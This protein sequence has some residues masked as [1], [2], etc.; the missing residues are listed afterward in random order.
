MKIWIS[1]GGTGG[2]LFPAIALAEELRARAPQCELLFLGGG[3]TTNR[4]FD[5]ELYPYAEIAC[6]GLGGKN[7]LALVRSSYRIWSGIR[8]SRQLLSAQTPDLVVGFGSFY[9]FPPLVAAAWGRIPLVLFAADR[10]PGRVIRLMARWAQVTA[11][12]FPET[13]S[14]LASPSVVVE[15]PLRQSCRGIATPQA[16]ARHYF[17]LDP[18]RP[19]L[20]VFG[21]SQGA[22]AINRLF[23]G[24]LTHLPP[25]FQLL[26]FTGDPQAAEELSSLYRSRGLLA[27]VKP[28]EPQMGLAWRAA[29]LAICRSGAGSV[30]EQREFEIPA[31]FIPYPYATDNHQELNADSVVN[32]FG[33]AVKLVEAHATPEKLASEIARLFAEDGKRLKEMQGAFRHYKGAFKRKSLGDVV[34]EKIHH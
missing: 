9:G 12:H 8:Q 4:Y 10:L 13:A 25:L 30:G 7:P 6:G 24:A 21:G 29:D 16:E 28:F 34:L 20:L 14:Q 1:A 33:G 31:I 3:L 15:M 2:H 22:R 23:S 11:V 19:T 5:R 26:H 17:G 18:D 32:T 27:C